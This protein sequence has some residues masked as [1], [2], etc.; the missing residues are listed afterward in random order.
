MGAETGKVLGW[1][2]TRGVGYAL[3]LF[4]I[5]AVDKSLSE[6]QILY[7]DLVPRYVQDVIKFI[8]GRVLG[9]TFTP[10]CNFTA[11]QYPIKGIDYY[12]TSVW[13]SKKN[14]MSFKQYSQKL[15][16]MA[17]SPSK[18]TTNNA[19]ASPQTSDLIWE[20]LQKGFSKTSQDFFA[21]SDVS[22]EEAFKDCQAYALSELYRRKSICYRD[23]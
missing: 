18:T 12:D 15:K 23:C 6:S 7:Q 5:N 19:A 13:G 11:Y 4:I 10:T 21:T 22:K 16:N 20:E 8:T 9:L 3:A 17:S 2:L 14:P 1:K